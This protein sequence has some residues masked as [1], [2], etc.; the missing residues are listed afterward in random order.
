MIN[1]ILTVALGIVFAFIATQNTAGVNFQLFNFSLLNIPL[2]LLLLGSLLIGLIVA[3]FIS[4]IDS[5]FSFFT[6]RNREHTIDSANSEI[7]SLNQR[8]YD[9]E[10][11]NAKLKGQYTEPVVTHPK[12]T[13][14]HRPRF[15]FLDRMRHSF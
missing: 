1:L 15:S 8:I 4:A 6:I 5:L 11:E 13:H 10:V 2:Y 14:D 9:L 3:G 7:Q 12:E